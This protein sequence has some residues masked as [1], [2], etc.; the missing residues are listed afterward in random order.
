MG[1]QTSDGSAS[2][3][4]IRLVCPKD[5]DPLIADGEG[6][7]C[8][9][10]HRYPVV[11]GIPIL[12]GDDLP[13]THPYFEESRRAGAEGAAPEEAASSETVDPFVQ[14]VV[15]GAIVIAAVVATMDRSRLFVTK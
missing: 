13:D 10:G 8:V 6:L 9:G 2:V 12:L 3:G 1:I 4:G 14:Q 5:H 15:T 11:G 7:R